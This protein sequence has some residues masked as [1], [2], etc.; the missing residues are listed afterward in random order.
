M[1]TQLLRTETDPTERGPA[2]GRAFTSR[3]APIGQL[4]GDRGCDDNGQAL[5]EF[6][7]VLPV[8][9]LLL[10]GILK[11]GILFNNYLQ[12]TDA[13]RSGART[14]AIERG[15]ATPCFDAAQAV[16]TSIGGGLNQNQVTITM[17][18]NPEDTQAVPP[19]P[20]NAMYIWQNGQGAAHP[21]NPNQVS[22]CG[23]TLVSGSAV[24]LTA[25]YPCDLNLLGIDFVPGCQ[26]SASVTERVE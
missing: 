23:F 16:L 9:M 19:D 20:P 12:L 15:Q 11:G 21:A 2:V 8:L 24:T 18:E 26:L 3:K 7:L 14:L 4:V 10:V 17:T 13:A 6:A 22:D 5:V 25:Q 1:D